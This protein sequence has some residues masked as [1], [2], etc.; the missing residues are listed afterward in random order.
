MTVNEFTQAQLLGLRGRKEQPSIVDQAVVVEGD[1]DAVG[2]VAWQHL[3][4][5]R[6][7]EPVFCCKTIIPDA[8][9]HLLAASG[10]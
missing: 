10:R 5:A 9:E 7:L 3:L 1:A 6:S 2:V 4:G 8:Q